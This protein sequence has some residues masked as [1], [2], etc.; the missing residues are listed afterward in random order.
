MAR[1]HLLWLA[2]LAAHCLAG[3]ELSDSA[4][5]EQ[6]GRSSAGRVVTPVNQV[7]ISAG[8][9]VDLPG[10]RPQALAFSPDGRILVATGKT[11]EII[12]MDPKRGG[13]SSMF[14]CRRRGRPRRQPFRPISCN[15]M[16]RNR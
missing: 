9:T 2:M 11:P 8:Q 14:L 5:S 15:P 13:F 6:V 3:D 4:L 7:V 16:M 10:M 1:F 12:V